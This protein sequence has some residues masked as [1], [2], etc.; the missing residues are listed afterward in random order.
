MKKYGDSLLEDPLLAGC[1]LIV[2]GLIL[3]WIAR[4]K[5]EGTRTYQQLSFA[6]ALGIGLSQA[7]AIL[8]GI[9]RSGSTIAA[10]LGARLNR[11]S[12]ATFSFL[13][14]IPAIGGAGVLE[15]KDL[16]WSSEGGGASSLPLYQ[17]AAGAL[18]S[19]IVG[20]ISLSWLLRWLQTGR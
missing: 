1:F 9:S 16:I 10:G 4:Q 14:A 2:T 3:L 5:V 11:Q 6:A 19:C 13:L 20:V 15:A 18:V 12:A 7:V 8:P 17:L